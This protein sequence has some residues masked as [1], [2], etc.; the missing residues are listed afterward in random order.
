MRL[1]FTVGQKEQ[2]QVEFVRGQ[3]LGNSRI[4]I[5]GKV[6]LRGP[7]VGLQE[8]SLIGT[9][10]RRYQYLYDLIAKR[11]FHIQRLRSWEVEIGENERHSLCIVKE[12]P[13]LFAALRPHKYRVLVDGAL[14]IERTGY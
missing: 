9:P 8:L 2:H 4:S 1:A 3:F 7:P 13:F 14:I 5:D 6:V 10:S 11:D 12:R